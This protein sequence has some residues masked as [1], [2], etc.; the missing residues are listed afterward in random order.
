MR[1]RLVYQ[2]AIS[3]HIAVGFAFSKLY[4]NPSGKGYQRPM[5]RKRAAD[6]ADYLSTG[7]SALY[8]PILLNA[9]EN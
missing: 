9:G 4:N 5:S 7:E 2:G 3:S 8:T 6:F 1:G